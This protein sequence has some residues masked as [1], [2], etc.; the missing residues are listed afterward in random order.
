MI[1][2]SGMDNHQLGV[3]IREAATTMVEDQS[4]FWKFEVG[5]SLVFVITDT[6]RNRMRMM[7][8]VAELDSLSS[9]QIQA[10]LA[11]NYD[12]AMDSRYCANNNVLWSAFLH[13]LA[14]LRSYQFHDAL[15]Q[16]VM[17]SRNFGGT[18]TSSGI[19]F[20]GDT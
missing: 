3:L 16:V 1:A 12:R 20:G 11:A 18:Y 19:V 14:E 10:V 6:S 17:L 5:D 2:P 13:P 4:G 7:T 8:P 15:D 9:E